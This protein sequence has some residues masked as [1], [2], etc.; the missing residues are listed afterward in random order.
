MLNIITIENN[1]LYLNILEVKL[2]FTGS[3][4]HILHVLTNNSKI[5]II[6]NN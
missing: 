5:F 3:L 6:T 1:I 2:Y 4:L